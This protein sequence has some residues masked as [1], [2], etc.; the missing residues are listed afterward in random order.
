MMAE[1]IAVLHGEELSLGLLTGPCLRPLLSLPRS[2][3]A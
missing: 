1:R 3:P 2:A